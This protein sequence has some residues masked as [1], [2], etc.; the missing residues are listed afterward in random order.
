MKKQ[1]AI[2][3]MA[4]ISIIT[5][6]DTDDSIDRSI[7][8]NDSED[9]NLPEYSEWGYNTFGAKMGR[10]YFVSCWHENPC[11]MEWH[12]S[13][14]TLELTMNGCQK[15]KK[16]SSYDS[17]AATK[18]DVS[19]TIIFPCD[20]VIN[21]CKKLYLLNGKN[22]DLT[23]PDIKVLVKR[24][25]NPQEAITDIRSGEL[26]FKRVQILYVNDRFEEAIVSGTF[27]I[28]YVSNGEKTWLSDGRFD[29]GV[30]PDLFW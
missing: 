6:C 8:I 29:L 30:T 11:I 18:E 17:Y 15:Y 23:D 7:W 14:K 2:I 25:D 22:F 10:N 1:L 19:L 4:A 20:S 16:N 21:N 9:Y 3:C 27:D 26:H 28:R 13:D 12:D 5:A 24:S